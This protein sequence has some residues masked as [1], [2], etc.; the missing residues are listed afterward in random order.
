[1]EWFAMGRSERSG[2]VRQRRLA[3]ALPLA[4]GLASTGCIALAD[5]DDVLTV[6]SAISLSAEPESMMSLSAE[7]NW[8]CVRGSGGRDPTDEPLDPSTE[9]TFDLPVIDVTTGVA[10][11]GLTV[12]VC[13]NFDVDCT[14]PIAGPFTANDERLQLTLPQGFNGFLEIESPATLPAIYFVPRPL[15]PGIRLPTPVRM[16]SAVAIQALGALAGVTVDLELGHLATAVVD[17]EGNRA[18]GVE[19]RLGSSI[20]TAFYLAE[21]RP[22]VMLDATTADGSGGFVNLPPGAYVLTALLDEGN[23]EIGAK[24][25]YVRPG[26]LSVTSVVPV[27]SRYGADSQSQ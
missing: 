13:A 1:M 23:R 3:R 7:P 21:D 14:M 24:T 26:W 9:F 17:C 10:P 12:H 27:G 20:G 11:P 5:G 22:A 8:D 25:I 18:S 2:H 15:A 16:I 4:A 6:D 19:F